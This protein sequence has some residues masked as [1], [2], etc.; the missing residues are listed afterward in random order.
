MDV[1]SLLF[2]EI[3]YDENGNA[4]GRKFGYKNI[5]YWIII[6]YFG[7]ILFSSKRKQIGGGGDP[8]SSFWKKI[9]KFIKWFNRKLNPLWA[10]WWGYNWNPED[11]DQQDIPLSFQILTFAIGI[12]LGLALSLFLIFVFIYLLFLINPL[13]FLM[14]ISE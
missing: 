9:R 8:G 2:G 13:S 14:W 10:I 6:I 1:K 12:P 11:P 7:N 5:I 3:E 4:I